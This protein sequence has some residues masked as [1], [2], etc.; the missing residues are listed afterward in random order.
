MIKLQTDSLDRY[1]GVQAEIHHASQFDETT[2]VCTTHLGKINMSKED[3][4]KTKV[5]LLLIDQSTTRGKLLDGTDCKIL[6]DRGA[7]RVVCQSNFISEINPYMDSLSLLL[8][9]KLFKLEM[10]QVLT[11]FIIFIIITIEGHIFEFYTVVSETHDNVNVVL[12]VKTFVELEVELSM[13]E[14]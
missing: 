7:T 11:F 10:E 1:E 12:G 2:T 13:R 4:L 14:L 5:Q 9:P 3:A 6:P 8:K